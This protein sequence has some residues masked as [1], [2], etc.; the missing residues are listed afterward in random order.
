MTAIKL[1]FVIKQI[2]STKNKTIFQQITVKL[3]ANLFLKKYIHSNCFD[4]I[5]RLCKLMTRAI[6]G[7][8]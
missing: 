5:P 7:A 4:V 3:N 6:L 1:M 2:S 8:L